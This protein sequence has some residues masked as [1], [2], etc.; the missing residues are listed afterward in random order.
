M[1]NRWLELHYIKQIIF[2]IPKFSSFLFFSFFFKIFFMR[3]KKTWKMHPDKE[4]LTILIIMTCI[5]GHYSQKCEIT[6]SPNTSAK[7]VIKTK[8]NP[9]IAQYTFPCTQW[10]KQTLSQWSRPGPHE[11]LLL[12]QCVQLQHSEDSW[13]FWRMQGYLVF[14]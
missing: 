11:L 4:L 1:Q 8:V 3:A 7:W 14:P 2:I 12:P 5:A 9:S 6:Q 10:V 13:H